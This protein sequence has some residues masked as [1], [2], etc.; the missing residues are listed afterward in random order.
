M[1]LRVLLYSDSFTDVLKCLAGNGQ[2][3]PNAEFKNDQNFLLLIKN[4]TLLEIVMSTVS[5]S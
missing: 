1:T 2:E 4:A 5:T 3:G